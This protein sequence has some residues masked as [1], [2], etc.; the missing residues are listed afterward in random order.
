MK[1]HP[2]PKAVSLLLSMAL[3]VQVGLP[4]MAAEDTA[5]AAQPAAAQNTDVMLTAD[6]VIPDTL[7]AAE[8]PAPA[9]GVVNK[10]SIPAAYQAAYDDMFRVSGSHITAIANN[11]GKYGGSVL[12]NLNDG[13]TATHWETGKPNTAAFKNTLTFTFDAPTELESVVYYPRTQGA[14]N[15]G[16]PTAFSIYGSQSASGEDFVLVVSGTAAASPGGTQIHFTPTTFQRLRFVFDEAQANWAACAEMAFY[17]EDSL[18]GEL[19][20]LFADGTMSSLKPEYQSVSVLE[21][22]LARAKAHP[23]QDLESK[24]QMALDIQTGAVDY[25]ADVMALEQRGDGVYHARKELLMS[26]YGSNIL[27]IGLAARPGET[28]KVYVDADDGAPLPTIMF[29][30]QMGKFSEWQRTFKLQ[31]GENVFTVPKIQR[32]SWSVKTNPGG[33][34]YMLNPYTPEEQG[35]APRIRIEG[36]TPYPL[37]RDGDDVDAF[38]SE[39]RDY[40]QQM[41]ENPATTVDVVDLYSDYIILNG[42]L[43]AAAPFLN[44]TQ[45]PQNTIEFHN[46]RI[47]QML[48]YAGLDDSSPI[49]SRGTARAL[50][51]IMQPFAAA[52]AASDHVGVQQTSINTFFKGKMVGWAYAHELGHTLDIIGGK[53]PEVTNNMWANRIIFEIQGEEDRIKSWDYDKIFRVKGS[54]DYAQI[55]DGVHDMGMWW[56]LCLMD[57]NYWP[58]YQR[59]YREGIAADMDLTMRERMAVVSSYALGVDVVEHFERYGFM[60]RN[61]NVNAALAALGVPAGEHVKPWYMW[62]KA[63]LDRESAFTQTYTPKVTS[64]ERSGENIKVSV[65]MDVSADAAL[66]GYEIRQDGKVLGFTKT[67]TFTTPYFTDDGQ[68]HVYTAQAYDLRMNVSE[69]SAPATVNLNAPV[70]KI[71]GSTLVALHEDFDPLH[72]VSAYTMAGADISDSIQVLSNPVDTERQGVYTVTYAVTDSEG[73]STETAVDINV[74]SAFDYLSDIQEVSATVGYKTLTKDKAISGGAITLLRNSTP[75][76]FDKGLGAHASSSIVYD[77]S[78]KDYSTFESYVGIDQAVKNS[79]AANATF[80]VLVDGTVRYDSGAMKATDDM[81]YVKLDISGAQRVELVADSNGANGS[82]HTVW[83][84]ARFALLSSAPVIYAPNSTFTDPADVDL[85]GILAQVTATDVEDGD[86]TAAITY[87]TNYVSGK[88]GSFDITYAVTDSDGNTTKLTRKI[89]VVNSAVYVSDTDWKSAKV[90]WGSIKRDLSLDGKTMK[91]D[92]ENGVQSYD[93]GLGVHAYSEVV[94]DLTDKDYYYFVSDVGIDATAAN[95]LSS[96]IFQVYVDG[97]LAAE[98]PIMRKG[99]PAEHLAVDLTGAS[100]LKLVVSTADNGN[101]NDHANWADAKFLIAVAEADK[102]ALSAAV[103]QVRTLD[104]SRYTADTWAV[105]SKALDA[106]ENV[107]NRPL[108]SQEEINDALTGL[109]EARDALVLHVDTTQVKAVLDFA[110]AADSLDY[111]DPSLKHADTRLYNIQAY[112]AVAEGILAKDDLTQQAADDAARALIYFLEDMGQTYVP[113][114]APV[115]FANQQ[116]PAGEAPVDEA[117]AD[118]TPADETP[119][120]NTP[121]DEAPADERP[122]GDAPADEAPADEAPAGDTPADEAPADGI[123]AGD[124]PVDEAPADET[125]VN[126]TPAG[127][128]LTDNEPPAKETPAD[129]TPANETSTEETSSQA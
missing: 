76:T 85:E 62:S 53:V 51:R 57:A 67:G 104:E 28:V 13:S 26:S 25:A 3:L 94:Y 65:S 96:V 33:A 14:A 22:L 116:T 122:A 123:P 11:G 102:D 120:G 50:I 43:Q 44:G 90:G 119:T 126:E 12:A 75:V 68:S 103:E 88:T 45:T 84:A 108:A 38:L 34:I 105:L 101:A 107:L 37:F 63:T 97:V 47:N 46:T 86:L 80:R 66:L 99:T 79:A 117:P 42:N 56:Q 35:A 19:D 39:L 78:G 127:E 87:E 59:A 121:V 114:G 72:V 110:R 8:E 111:V 125:P 36:A 129:E 77:V 60:E 31:Q 73:Y 109:N 58:N 64:V 124:T 89:V 70:F 18:P 32:D 113:G 61:G 54:D 24:V 30:Q 29:T 21:E 93:K 7:A 17:R 52:Y 1:K 74:V 4:A 15:K 106:A 10:F 100:T 16:F 5:D 27:P 9:P 55:T 2:L 118:E 6:D 23:N 83:A 98:T 128:T 82:D 41:T 81:R 92:T 71:T 115:N 20:G 112:I 69:V 48:E 95:H 40:Q 49:H 91:L